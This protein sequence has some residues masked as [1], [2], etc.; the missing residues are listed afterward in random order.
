MIVEVVGVMLE[1][2]HIRLLAR[3]QILTL[4]QCLSCIKASTILLISGVSKNFPILLLSK[5]FPLQLA[6]LHLQ[7]PHSLLP[8]ARH[9]LHLHH[10]LLTAHHSLLILLFH[11]HKSL[12]T[13][14]HLFDLLLCLLELLEQETI[15]L[16]LFL[17]LCC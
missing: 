6:H 17:V 4:T 8:L 2:H 9:L 3:H 12:N 10:L 11:C 16:P 1:C 15:I 13:L 7:V 14:L 5:Q